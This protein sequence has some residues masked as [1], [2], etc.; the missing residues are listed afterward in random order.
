MSH[1]LH[2][3]AR[4]FTVALLMVG[5]LLATN[6]CALGLMKP[7]PQA[8]S[9]HGH[10]HGGSEDS[11]K[12]LPADGM[13][14]CCRALNAAPVQA[15]VDVK[16]DPTKFQLHLYAVSLELAARIAAPSTTSLFSDTGPPRAMS[17]A[18]SVLQRSLLGHAPPLAV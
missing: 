17:F 12:K 6:H 11:G 1:R 16:F 15:K 5:W 18:E 4:V 3:Q 8:K 7:G 13:R 10:C 9:E 14:E 2:L